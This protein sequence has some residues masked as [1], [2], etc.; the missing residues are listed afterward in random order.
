MPKPQQK[1]IDFPFIEHHETVR[2]LPQFRVMFILRGLPGSGKST[3]A[4]AILQQYR[5]HAIVCS[6]DYYR[7]NKDGEYVWHEDTL[8]ETHN[9][10][11]RRAE[12]FAA[13]NKPVLI[14]GEPDYSIPHSTAIV[15]LFL[16]TKKSDNCTH[17]LT[18]NRSV[19]DVK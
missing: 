14:I 16:F 7:Y 1:F 13:L 12:R 4:D 3:I 19:L 18:S 2:L 15:L 9:K 8:Q 11:Q 17:V 6:A 10:C 5:D